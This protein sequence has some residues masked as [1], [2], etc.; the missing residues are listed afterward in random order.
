MID[1]VKRRGVPAE[2][3]SPG[4]N[5]KRAR[6]ISVSEFIK[7]KV[8]FPRKGAEK[9]I[10]QVLYFGIERHDDLVDALVILV[11]KVFEQENKRFVI[12]S[13]YLKKQ[14]TLQEAERDAEE[15]MRLC[16]EA[17]RSGDPIL[18]RKYYDHVNE[19]RRNYYREE[20]RIIGGKLL[21]DRLVQYRRGY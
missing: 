16:Q 12:P 14:S 8:E 20:E 9:L 10:N 7:Q 19:R 11:L 2:G 15:E 3:V 6:L 13:P 17:Q 18:W 4:G 1:F 21:H 5:D